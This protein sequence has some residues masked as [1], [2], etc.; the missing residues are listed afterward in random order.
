MVVVVLLLL[1]LLLLLLCVQRLNPNQLLLLQLQPVQ[2]AL[3]S[4]HGS[5]LDLHLEVAPLGLRVGR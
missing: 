3:S 5:S 4:L 2:A 1:L